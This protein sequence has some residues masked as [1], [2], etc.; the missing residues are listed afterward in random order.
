MREPPRIPEATL[1]A[2]LNDQYAITAVCL[3]FLPLGHD[4]LAAVYRVDSGQSASYLLKVTSRPLHEAAFRLPHYLTDLGIAPVVAPL[5]TRR[6]A[7]WAA[8]DGAPGWTAIVYPYIA[9]ETS[10]RPAMTDAQWWA[11]GAALKRIHQA[12]LPTQGFP[13]LRRETFDPAEYIRCVHAFAARPITDGD[14]LKLAL[15]DAWLRHRSTLHAMLRGMD[16]LARSLRQ[17]SGPFVICHADLHPGNIIRTVDGRVFLIDW[18]DVMLAPKE[19]DFLFAADPLPHDA[20]GSGASPFF[21][22]YEPADVDWVALTYYR[23]E[24]NVTDL[25]EYARDVLERDDLTDDTKAE[26]IRMIERVFA[27]S[28]MMNAAWAAAAHLPPDLKIR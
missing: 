24:R 19:R 23:F 2:T 22:G 6:N 3:E 1:R 27:P 7:L 28:D 17:R 18:D 20:T 16:R 4:S 5:S 15:A 11:V 10:W 12:P 25:I 9:G 21:V 26:S 8:I 14:P 13:S